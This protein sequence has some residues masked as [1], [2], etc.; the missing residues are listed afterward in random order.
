MKRNDN[1]KSKEIIKIIY[2]S[3]ILISA[4]L[5][6]ILQSVKEI[7]FVYNQF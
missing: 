5:L 2:L 4:Y 1:K 6:L 3:L 7:P